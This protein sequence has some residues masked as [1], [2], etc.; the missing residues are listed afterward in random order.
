M[1][2]NKAQTALIEWGA[3]S[4]RLTTTTFRTTKQIEIQDKI[5]MVED[6]CYAPTNDND[7]SI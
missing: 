3:V 7:E 5:N 6:L 1:L 2:T 4:S